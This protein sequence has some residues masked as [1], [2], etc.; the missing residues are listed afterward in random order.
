MKSLF[1]LFRARFR[2]GFEDDS[3]FPPGSRRPPDF[4]KSKID[5]PAVRQRRSG[6]AI[7]LIGIVGTLAGGLIVNYISTATYDGVKSCFIHICAFVKSC[8]CGGHI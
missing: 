5:F 1:N 2:S 4:P 7:S 6:L 8:F 3:G